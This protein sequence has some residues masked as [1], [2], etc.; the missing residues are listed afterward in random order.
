MLGSLSSFLGMKEGMRRCG[1]EGRSKRMRDEEMMDK[2]NTKK[3]A[4]SEKSTGDLVPFGFFFFLSLSRE[5][6]MWI[7]ELDVFGS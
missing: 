7:A 2:K 1:D 4:F 5:I 3:V 6:Q